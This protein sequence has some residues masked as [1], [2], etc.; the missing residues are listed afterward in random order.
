MS[1]I[2]PGLARTLDAAR[3]S[4]FDARCRHFMSTGT[5]MTLRLEALPPRHSLPAGIA[6]RAAPQAVVHASRAR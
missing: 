6:Y 3:H 4:C 1:Q 5:V 2:H